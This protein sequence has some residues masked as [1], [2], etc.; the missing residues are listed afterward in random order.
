[1]PL[2]LSTWVNTLLLLY[3]SAVDAIQSPDHESK[4]KNIRTQA[5]LHGLMLHDP[6]I[7]GHNP[8]DV[9]NAFN[10]IS[11]TAPR[12]ADQVLIMQPLIRKRLSQGVLDP[13]EVH[14][15]MQMNQGGQKVQQPQP[16]PSVI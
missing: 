1:M 15:I 3:P 5:M 14:Q 4:L 10:E 7:K 16:S 2:Y 13:F 9:I 11:E 8:E 6:V 12:L